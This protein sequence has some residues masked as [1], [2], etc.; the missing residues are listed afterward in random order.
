MIYLSTLHAP[1]SEQRIGPT[2]SYLLDKRPC[3]VVIETAR[4][5]PL[6]AVA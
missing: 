6:P 3:R 4:A 2:A 5:A 1:M